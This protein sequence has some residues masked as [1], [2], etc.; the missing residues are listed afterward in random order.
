MFDSEGCI[1]GRHSCEEVNEWNSFEAKPG[2]SIL[3]ML[4]ARLVAVVYPASTFVQEL[5]KT[6]IMNRK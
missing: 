2:L 4:D 6:K 3:V 1:A 5:S